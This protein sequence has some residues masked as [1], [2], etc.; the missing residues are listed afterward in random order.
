MQ[1]MCV[2]EG[3]REES[4]AILPMAK[5]FALLQIGQIAFNS[6]SERQKHTKA[7]RPHV[8]ND[9]PQLPVFHSSIETVSVCGAFQKIRNCPA[10]GAAARLRRAPCQSPRFT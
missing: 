7:Q 10:A 9:A 5:R 1:K 8:N 4:V 3:S 2:V 6:G